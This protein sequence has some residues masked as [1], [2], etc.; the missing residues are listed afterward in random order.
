M[1]TEESVKT[2]T[3]QLQPL[4]SAGGNIK[5]Y[6]LQVV[7]KHI[8]LDD[9]SAKPLLIQMGCC[10]NDAE[11]NLG[12]FLNMLFY[13]APRRELSLP[14]A[15]AAAGGIHAWNAQHEDVK[16]LLTMLSSMCRAT[17]VQDALREVRAIMSLG[18][19]LWT[20]A[21]MR[22]LC[23]R[24][25]NLFYATIA[26]EPALIL[27]SVYTP[28]VGEACQKFGK[29]PLYSRG[30]YLCI[31]EKGRLKEVLKEYADA[32][33]EKD[34]SGNY[35]C[36][37]IVF[38]DGGRILGLGDLGAWGMGIP[39]GKLDL[40]TV[41]GGFNP[42][43]TI[44]VI[45]DAGC[46]G[47]EGNTDRLV[48]R[49]SPQYTGAK[50]PRVT[51]TSA[52]KTVVNSAYYGDNNLIAEFMQGATELFGRTCLLQFEDFNSNDAFPL[53]AEYRDKYL[54]Y[55]DDIQGTAAVA[56]AGLFGA[57]KLRDPGCVDLRSA[58]L[59]EKFFFHGAGSANIG[60][61]KLLN[62]EVG[63]PKSSIVVTNSRG[64]IWVSEDG[65]KGNYR[66]D[67]QKAFGQIGEPTFNSKDLT[68][69][70][71]NV[72]PGCAIGAVG[73]V[74]GCFNKSMVDAMCSVNDQRPTIFALSNPKT[75]AEVTADD[76]YKWSNGKVIYGS[77]TWFAPVEVNGK[78][79]SAGQVN[80]VYIFPGMSF[81]AVC[82]QAKS[83]P[84][85]LFMVAAEAVA[86]CLDAE[87][88]EKDMVVPRRDRIGEVGLEV[89][90]AVAL[91]AQ[92]MG[93]A[94]RDLGSD[95]NAVKA[96]LESMSWK[97]QV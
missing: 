67:E 81:G 80:N 47:P 11:V 70:V 38:S 56:L 13:G 29:M 75:Q 7:L 30:C 5:G 9:G 12:R 73:V 92:A 72:R 65:T 31:T 34:A 82:C 78:V 93:L 26:A 6:D 35:L 84:E 79:H 83:I 8:G 1:G 48:I 3:Q 95:R 96:R 90:T 27:P 97:P 21:Y 63:V 40:Y 14:K 61:M 28:T 16:Q 42:R 88:L 23:D 22:K 33:L 15:V 24:N 49:D 74:P 32:E 45:I 4:T 86:N 18:H 44:P 76:A 69:L 17:T 51:H 55:N 36:D 20:Y 62:E 94:G 68:T 57:V 54:T 43:R 77:G 85:R 66:N 64:I 2:I 25:M 71:E 59:K 19:N 46:H 37:C 52:Q 53:L 91:E 89:A 41:C 87:D 39:I 58:L 50:Q 60:L 10:T